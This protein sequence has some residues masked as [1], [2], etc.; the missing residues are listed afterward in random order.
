MPYTGTDLRACGVPASPNADMDADSTI[1][2]T[3]HEHMEAVTDPMLNAWYDPSGFEI[4]DKCA[5]NFGALDK[6]GGQANL[7]LNGHFYIIQQEWSNA[8]AACVK[9]YP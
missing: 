6:A 8:S 5:W 2:V 9:T 7:Q 4:A 3:S 1:N